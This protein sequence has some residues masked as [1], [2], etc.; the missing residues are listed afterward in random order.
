[1]SQ[2]LHSQNLVLLLEVPYQL[3]EPLDTHSSFLD[4][5]LTTGFWA[6]GRRS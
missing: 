5:K 2:E 6:S 1:M 3:L 4:I